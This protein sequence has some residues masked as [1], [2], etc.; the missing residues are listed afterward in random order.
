MH[1]GV[2]RQDDNMTAMRCGFPELYERVMS[3]EELLKNPGEFSDI[4]DSLVVSVD[5][6]SSRTKIGALLVQVPEKPPVRMNS[7]YD[8]EHEAAVWCKGVEGMDKKVLLVFGLGN[9]VFAREIIRRKKKGAKVLIYE[10]SAKIFFF[11]LRHFDIRFC[12]QDPDVRLIVEGINEDLFGG[13]MELMLTPDNYED[14]QFIL[15]P[16][17]QELFSESRERMVS[18]YVSEGLGWMQ[19]YRNMERKRLYISP[20]NQLHNLKYLA[21]NTVVPH[22]EGVFPKDVPVLLV[23]AGPSLKEEIEVLRNAGDKAFL[24]AAD[25]ALPYLMEENVIP[26]AFVCIEADKP[27]WFFEDERIRE[28]PA[29]VKVDTTHELLDIHRAEK[30]FGYDMGFMQRVYEAYGVKQSRYRYGSNGMTSLFSI[31]DEIGVKNVIFVGQDMCFGKDK[32]THVGGRNEGFSENDTFMC[33]NN[34]GEM[35][36]SR[37]DWSRFIRWYGNAIR[38]C[39]MEHVIN[40]SLYGAKIEGTEV[41]PLRAALDRYGREHVSFRDVLRKADRTFARG[42]RSFDL[43]KLYD[44]CAGELEEIKKAIRQNP[45]A[46]ERGG[47]MVYGLLEKYEIANEEEDFVKSQASGIRKLEQLIARCR[48]DLAKEASQGTKG[49]LI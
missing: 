41:M 21:D 23:G 40:T 12:F 42:N 45:R 25:S 44:Q 46:E 48:R 4:P 2:K 8:P 34:Q 1:T 11:V 5:Q 13:V 7:S 16:E 24:F 14:Y 22:L 29:F 10:P 33:E 27:M 39:G 17:M 32:V 19:T 18:L 36:Q 3:S 20:Y 9:G 43:A 47:Y 28:I 6:I 38:D 26:D 37:I 31:C 30:I 35:V 15:C 49:D